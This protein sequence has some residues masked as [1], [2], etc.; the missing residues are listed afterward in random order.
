M[1]YLLL[2]FSFLVGLLLMALGYFIGA[3]WGRPAEGK[4]PEPLPLSLRQVA[5]SMEGAAGVTL[6][7]AEDLQTYGE[8]VEAMADSIPSKAE[9]AEAVS[10]DGRDFLDDL[11][12]L[13]DILRQR[14]ERAE[15]RLHEQALELKAYMSEA[16]RDTLTDLPNRRAFHEELSRRLAEAG[17]YNRPLTVMLLDVDHFK[18]INDRYGHAAGDHVLCALADQFRAVVRRSDLA[19]RYGGEEFA[20]ILPMSTVEGGI[21]LG[22][23]M[24]ASVAE[25]AVTWEEARIRVTLSAG[26]AQWHPDETA[27]ELLHRADEA[28]YAAK[29][30]GRNAVAWHDGKQIH[31]V[32][33]PTG[34]A[35]ESP[36]GL[37][38]AAGLDGTWSEPRFRSACEALRGELERLAGGRNS[39]TADPQSTRRG[40]R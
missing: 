21:H 33:R 9:E 39:G 40:D 6:D 4:Q 25:L 29:H 3:R 16:R 34:R 17:R 18:R 31:V 30:A 14:L 26:A 8:L 10:D 11:R 22:E 2:T 19:A 35:A 38:T 23:R 37:G 27:A 36:A 15:R 24:R 12:V 32:P 5:Q 13:N 1:P 7:V 28:L 20:V